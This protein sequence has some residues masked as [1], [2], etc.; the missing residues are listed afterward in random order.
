MFFPRTETTGNFLLRRSR[1]NYG[2]CGMT[3][4][5]SSSWPIKPGSRRTPNSPSSATSY[6]TSSPSWVFQCKPS[7]PQRGGS[8]GNRHLG[9]GLISSMRPGSSTFYGWIVK[10]REKTLKYETSPSPPLPSRH[11]CHWRVTNDDRAAS[12]PYRIDFPF[13]TSRERIK[14]CFQVRNDSCQ[15]TRNARWIFSRGKIARKP[16]IFRRIH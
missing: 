1:P 5:R 9:C 15:L 10:M 6:G 2:N 8:I 4:I 11:R 16:E 14:N 3:A 12:S 13:D 7:S